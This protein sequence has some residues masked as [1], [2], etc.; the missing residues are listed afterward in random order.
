MNR[1]VDEV[2]GEVDEFSRRA[3]HRVLEKVEW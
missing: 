3:A 1:V 2:G